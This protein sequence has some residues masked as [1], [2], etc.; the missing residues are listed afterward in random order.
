[1]TYSKASLAATLLVA[2][3]STSLA[4]QCNFDKKVGSCTGMVSILSTSGSGKSHNAEIS[5]Q[6]S[7]GACS[8][9]EY[10]LH[11]TPQTALIRSS[12]IEHES[13][14]GTKQLKPKDIKVIQCTAYQGGGAASGVTSD[15]RA[16]YGRCVDDA[17]M[18]A[19]LDS[20]YANINVMIADETLASMKEM[21][22]YF[23]ADNQ[24]NPRW[25]RRQQILKS[26]L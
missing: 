22:D 13:V 3:T 6:S 15:Q 23:A 7:T 8:K 25:I 14:F 11:N 21:Q 17:K 19:E 20:Q 4:Q 10:Y 9:V 26:C 24:D 2:F 5:I 12:G 16:R 1:M 18:I